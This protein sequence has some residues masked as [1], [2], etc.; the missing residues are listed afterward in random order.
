MVDFKRQTNRSTR[1]DKTTNINLFLNGLEFAVQ[2][3]KSWGDFSSNNKYNPI[4][5]IR[6]DKKNYIFT[7]EEFKEK[8]RK[9]LKE[10]E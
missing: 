7:L 8:L 4:I 1:M 9:A 2:E 6:L 3:S 5:G 10:E